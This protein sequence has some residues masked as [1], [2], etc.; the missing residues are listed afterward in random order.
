MAADQ[1]LHRA[2]KLICFLCFP[3]SEKPGNAQEAG[4]G[5]CQGSDPDWPK[6]DPIPYGVM[7]SHESWSIEGG[8]GKC[9]G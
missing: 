6:E 3:T 4:R 2:K 7:L 9:S 5:H 1:C 8:R